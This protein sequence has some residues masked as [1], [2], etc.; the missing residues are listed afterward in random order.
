MPVCSNC[1]Y[2]YVEGILICPD[3]N[4]TLVDAVELKEYERLS[5]NDWVLIYK[6][7][8]EI[9]IEMIKNNLESA[10]V[11]TSVISQKDSS[12]P[13]PGNLSFIKLFV[14]KSDVEESL[15]F[16]QEVMKNTN[17]SEQEDDVE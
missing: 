14:K 9:D 6:S 4:S 11:E 5:E 7:F 2:E 10:D 16:I 3:C 12:F 15:A 1:G 17:K 8:N 13:A